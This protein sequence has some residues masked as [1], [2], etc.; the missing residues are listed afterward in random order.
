ML[1]DGA[2]QHFVPA[3]QAA[4]GQVVQPGAGEAARHAPET[5]SSPA[6]QA[7]PQAPQ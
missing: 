1:P 2:G 3:P 6:E 4:H 7:F 5:H